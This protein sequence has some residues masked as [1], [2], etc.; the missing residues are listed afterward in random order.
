MKMGER[1]PIKLKTVN[2]RLLKHTFEF[3][4]RES[5]KKR[6]RGM[7]MRESLS[8]FELNDKRNFGLF[9]LKL[10]FKLYQNYCATQNSTKIV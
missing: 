1:T 7:M 4:F 10:I 3:G 5:E 6:E 9:V 2:S 8:E